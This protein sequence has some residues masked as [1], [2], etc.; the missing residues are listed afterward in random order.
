MTLKDLLRDR[1]SEKAG[2][3]KMAPMHGMDMGPI[4][5]ALGEQTIPLDESPASRANLIQALMNKFGKGFKLH[6]LAKTALEHYDREADLAKVIKQ[7]RSQ[8]HE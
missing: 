6:P 4:H 7:N 3:D 8:F 5:A 2:S 1:D